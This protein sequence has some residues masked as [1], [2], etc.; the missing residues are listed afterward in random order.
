[1]TV[2]FGVLGVL[3]VVEGGYIGV[4]SPR[5]AFPG[6][7]MALVGVLFCLMALRPGTVTVDHE[8]LHLCALI[9][10]RVIPWS[11]VRSFRAV[12]RSGRSW[13]YVYVDIGTGKSAWL[14][15]TGG[16][17]ARVERIAAELTQAHREYLAGAMAGYGRH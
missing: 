1:L 16:T 10:N 15:G 6:S 13:S 8:G 2:F 17:D 14:R 7:V 4:T 5:S 9:R 12:L 3:E 11:D